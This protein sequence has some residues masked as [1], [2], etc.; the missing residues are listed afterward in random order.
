[1]DT[2]G[3]PAPPEPP[4]AQHG[5][6]LPRVWIGYLLG[7]VT[8][9]L[10]MVA[11]SRHPELLKEPGI[12]PLYLF[13]SIFVGFVYWLVC[14]YRIFLVLDAVPEW[15]HAISPARAAG[16][17]LIPLYNLYWCFR[18]PRTIAE[19]VNA[20]SGRPMM[21]PVAVGATVLLAFLLRFLDPGLGLL[22]SFLPISHVAESVRRAVALPHREPGEP[23]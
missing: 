10:Q 14:V 5:P 6:S 1:M 9:V 3:Y 7:F 8:I 16:F 22:L 11:V 15:Q 20:R 18:W 17:H 4:Q 23:Q 12:P 19:F 13:L 2:S 21:R